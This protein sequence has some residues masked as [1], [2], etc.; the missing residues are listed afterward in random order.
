MGS[1]IVA[2]EAAIHRVPLWAATYPECCNS[3]AALIGL[4]ANNVLR[5]G[6]YW[7]FAGGDELVLPRLAAHELSHRLRCFLPAEIDLNLGSV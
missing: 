2:L 4:R 7:R 5:L 1:Q 6:H 3:C